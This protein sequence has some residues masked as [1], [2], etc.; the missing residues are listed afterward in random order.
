L[1][2]PPALPTAAYVPTTALALGVEA[3]VAV[4]AALRSG[5]AEARATFECSLD[6]PFEHA[7]F[8]ILAG[9]EPLLESL[10]RFRP[11]PDDLAWLLSVGIIDGQ[12]R[13]LLATM[14][15]SCDVEAVL[16]GSVVFPG[17]PVL[18]V[19]GPF[20]QAQMVA[21]LVQS[22]LSDATL[23]ATKTM[24]CSLA[25]EGSEIIE[26]SA[27]VAHRL[28]GCPLLARAA[29]V[30]GASATTCTIASRRFG[31][32]LRAMQPLSTVLSTSSETLAYESWLDAAPDLAVLRLDA[33]DAMAGGA[34]VIAAIK[35]RPKKSTWHA[36]QVAI[37]LGSGDRAE[38]AT[39]LTRAFVASGVRPPIVAASGDLDEWR[40]SELR[41]RQAPITSF[42]LGPHTLQLTPPPVRYDLVAI[43]E[44][45]DWAPRVRLGAS[46]PASS[47]PGRKVLMR[48]FDEE[49]RPV[50]DL[51]H[52][53]SERL[54]SARDLKITDRATGFVTRLPSACTSTPLL[55]KVIRAGKRVARP[56]GVYETRERARKSVASLFD[57]Y[58]RL[59]SPR[60]YP[61]GMTPTLV[62]LK[63]D[64]VSSLTSG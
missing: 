6:V 46:L 17:E 54:T 23:V 15:F 26:A 51:A 27:F 44:G 4:R 22:A 50:G 63:A 5:A 40:I 47:D 28:G 31:I 53:T 33:K 11:K 10:E 59:T 24:R 45:G 2:A 38:L 19:D 1:P 60:H 12:T 55:A 52:A 61:T 29:F 20:W 14:R 21:T 41:R 37:E 42:I 3:F 48:Y 36:H 25:A 57:R 32:P 16:E 7:G 64:L 62:K 13:D 9:I 34:R 43:E 58:V 30:G 35:K 18:A 49:G 56:E 8:M 39:E